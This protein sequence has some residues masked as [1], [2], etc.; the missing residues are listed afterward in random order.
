MLS[1]GQSHDVD[2]Y[3]ADMF[4]SDDSALASALAASA[5]AGLPPIAV[6]APKKD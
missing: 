1:V 2:D 3:L 4:A 6:S 5:E